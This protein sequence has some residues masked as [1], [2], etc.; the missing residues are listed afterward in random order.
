MARIRKLVLAITAASALSTGVAHALGLG[1]ISLQ[2]ALNQPLVAE[3]ELLDINGLGA[4]EIMPSLASAEDFQR[5]GVDRPFFLNDLRFTPVVNAQGKSVIRISSSKPVREPYLNF[6]VEVYWPSG[7]AL[8]EY[9]VLLDPPL[10]NPQFTVDVAPQLAQAAPQ[11]PAS[12]AQVQ[13]QTQVQPQPDAQPQLYP[14]RS[15]PLSPREARVRPAAATQPAEQ[16]QYRTVAHDTLWEIAMRHRRGN[17]SVQQTMLAIQ[18][19]NPGAFIDNNINLLKAGQVL[20]LPDEQQIASRSRTE[21]IARVAEQNAAWQAWRQAR[22]LAAGERQ[23]D[24]T[25]RT[26]AGAAPERVDIGDSLRLVAGTDGRV[27][28]GEDS[29]STDASVL[30]DRLAVAQENLDTSRR[31]SAELESRM[32]D[33]QSQLDKLQRL[34]ELKDN[35]LARLQARLAEEQAAAAEAPQTPA[36]EAAPQAAPD[37]A[38]PNEAQDNAA[39]PQAVLEPMPEATEAPMAQPAPEPADVLPSVVPAA[40]AEEPAE[41]SG[42]QGY[43]DRLLADP[44]LL[45]AIG[46]GSLLALLLALMALSRRNALKEAELHD[47]IADE[48]QAFSEELALPSSSF[49]DLGNVTRASK[50]GDDEMDVLGEANIYIAYGRFNQAAELLLNALDDTPERRDLRLKLMEVFAEQ[51]DRAGFQQ[52]EA[53]LREIG[54]AEEEIRALKTRYPDIAQAPAVST[55]A[56]AAGAAATAGAAVL[57]D[58]Q[59]DDEPLSGFTDLSFDEPLP[60]SA[61]AEQ[62]FDKPLDF[63]SLDFDLQLDTEPTVGD[64]PMQAPEAAAEPLAVEAPAELLAEPEFTLQDDPFQE[65]ESADDQLELVENEDDLPA[66]DLDAIETPIEEPALEPLPEDFDLSLAE[67]EQLLSEDEPEPSAVDDFE[68]ELERVNAQLDNITEELEMPAVEP[69]PFD[70]T[71]L[72]PLEDDED[73]DFLSGT[74]ETATKLDLARAYIDMGDNEGARDILDEVLGE[75]DENQKNEARELMARLS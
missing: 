60:S 19:L 49:D 2:S 65:R 25:R 23:L 24:A 6:L 38:Q 40:A 72:G 21:A 50:T 4:G 74:N 26:A 68:A 32:G 58:G 28:E 61:A 13:P 64:L 3:I 35:Q 15:A 8:R 56:L 62:D 16:T 45:G 34:I 20:R 71:D 47:G 1:E 70:I 18:D 39:H 43:I 46:G 55:S 37:E 48:D 73:F 51:G 33:L 12:Q 63:D 31:A 36:P 53:E 59:D 22:A 7:R 5:A 52:Q 30:A 54:G 27:A 44:L 29:G 11:A 17:A 75:G 66:L 67:A 9:T 42:L 41:R 69:P 57:A 10:Y 14:P